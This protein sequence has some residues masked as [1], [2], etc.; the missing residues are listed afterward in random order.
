MSPEFEEKIR[1][2]HLIAQSA[3][4]L[5]AGNYSDPQVE[6][7]S[8]KMDDVFQFLDSIVRDLNKLAP[9]H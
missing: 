8:G 2:A 7:L 3:L 4:E 9:W 6:E 5:I 1:K